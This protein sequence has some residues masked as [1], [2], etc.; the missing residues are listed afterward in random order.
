MGIGYHRSGSAC[1]PSKGK[2]GRWSALFCNHQTHLYNDDLQS[3]GAVYIGVN[4]A[5][6]WT[7]PLVEIRA[8]R[9]SGDEGMGA[10]AGLEGGSKRGGEA[11]A[12][13]FLAS[14]LGGVGAR[15]LVDNCAW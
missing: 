5:T 8:M 15:S 2:R 6:T 4:A 7:E 13:V 12:P 10:E 9:R 3:G 1:N 14:R 11:E